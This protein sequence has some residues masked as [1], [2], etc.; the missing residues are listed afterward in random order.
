MPRPNRDRTVLAEE[1]LARRVAFEREARGWTYEGTAKRMTNIGCPIQPTAIYKIEKGEPRRRISVDELVAFA[2][3]FD[4]EVQEMLMPVGAVLNDAA[5]TYLEGAYEAQRAITTAV[6]EAVNVTV[7]LYRFTVE[8]GLAADLDVAELLKE[9][10]G[11]VR[12]HEA[13]GELSKAVQD[14]CDKVEGA[15]VH[16]L[17]TIV[18]S[19]ET[20]VREEGVVDG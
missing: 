17:E 5:K 14:S 15:V 4:F 10:T 7:G 3:V 18:D 1:N 9:M 8:Y 20:V 12:S 19:A 16:L 2:K 11:E 13:D 6:T